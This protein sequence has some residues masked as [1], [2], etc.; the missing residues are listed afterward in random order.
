[1]NYKLWI[2]LRFDYPKKYLKILS[3][4]E[5]PRGVETTIEVIAHNIGD[6]DFP[7]GIFNEISSTNKTGG[8]EGLKSFYTVKKQISKIEKNQNKKIYDWY[9]E[10]RLPGLTW[11]QCNIK[12][13]DEKD[14]IDFYQHSKIEKEGKMEIFRDAYTVIDKENLDIQLS[15]T[16]INAKLKKLVRKEN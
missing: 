1:M 12:P 4:N 14:T 15:L 13:L 5:V 6:S 2:E 8:G 3:A 16:E 9:T 10:F 7:G 11:I